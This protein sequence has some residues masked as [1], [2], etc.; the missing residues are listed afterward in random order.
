[1]PESSHDSLQRLL[2]VMEVDPD[3]NLIH[4]DVIGLHDV[5]TFQGQSVAEAVQAF[6]ESV[7]DYLAW[8]AGKG[9]AQRR[10]LTARSW[11]SL[12]PRST[13]AYA[14]LRNPVP[15][16]ST[17][18]RSRRWSSW[19]TITNPKRRSNQTINGKRIQTES[20]GEK[21]SRLVRRNPALPRESR[22]YGQSH[23]RTHRPGS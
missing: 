23:R 21:R 4:G 15:P 7:D 14:N 22:D 19:L 17:N 5:I 10:R 6:R 8:C 11:F 16:A 3:A 2:G 20:V 1:M 12:I 9:Q 18:W 13:G